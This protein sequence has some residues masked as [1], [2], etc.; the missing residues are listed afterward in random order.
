MFFE[1]KIVA[2]CNFAGNMG[3]SKKWFPMRAY[4]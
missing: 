2:L 1:K 4:F 3:T